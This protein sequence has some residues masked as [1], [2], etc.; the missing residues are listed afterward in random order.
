V[1][2]QTAAGSASI[3]ITQALTIDFR[4]QMAAAGSDSVAMRNFTVVR[5]PAQSNP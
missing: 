5:Y 4:G 3:D 2:F 1:A